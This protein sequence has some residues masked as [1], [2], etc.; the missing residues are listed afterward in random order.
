[1]DTELQGL[2]AL[3]VE[4][5]G[6]VAVTYGLSVIGAVIILIAGFWVAGRAKRALEGWV[7]RFRG[8]DETLV[9]FLGG[10]VRYTII[11]VTLLAVLS[12]F[13]IQT[14]SLLAVLGAAG[15]AIGL[16][17]QGTLANVAAGVM[18]LF[19]RPFRIGDY[20]ESGSIAGTVTDMSLFN[21]M[22]STPD[23]VKIVVP[24]SDLWTSP[25]RNYSANPTRRVEIACGISY[26]DDIGKALGILRTTVGNDPRVLTNPEPVYAVKAL[27][28]SSVDVMA[29]VW[30]ATDD[31]WPFTFDKT[32]AVK[33]AFD[34]GGITIPFPTRTFVQAGTKAAD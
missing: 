30:V 31:F 14:A 32:R 16:A 24:N 29:R 1:M 28:D 26:G 20:I 25:I 12:Q 19:L 2:A 17:L 9:R 21:V 8:I 34:A 27:G 6:E 23:N 10:M 13:G 33:E 18:I 11:I 7:R 5:L 3:A 4:T 15:L 22:L